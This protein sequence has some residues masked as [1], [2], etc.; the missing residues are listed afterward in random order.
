MAMRPVSSSTRATSVKVPPM[1]MPIRHAMRLFPAHSGTTASHHARAP[2]RR[3]LPPDA[4]LR[5][6]L[7]GGRLLPGQGRRGLAAAHALSEADA[8]AGTRCRS[9]RRSRCWTCRGWSSRST[10]WSPTSCRCSAIAAAAI[11]CWRMSPP[12]WRFLWTTQV[13]APA[14]IVFALL[15]TVDRD[16]GLQHGVRRAAGGERPEA[17]RECRV[18]QPAMAMVQ[19]RG[20]G[21][22]ARRRRADRDPVGRPAPCTP[23]APSPPRRRSR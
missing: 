20:D 2:P 15:L 17:S 1:S 8:R 12:L 22:F 18:H 5:H 9:P 4:V 6:R 16:G 21:G 3:H 14:A 23:P 11:C 13:L 10:A 19:R 7:Y